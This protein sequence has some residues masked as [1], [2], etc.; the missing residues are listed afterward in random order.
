MQE[1]EQVAIAKGIIQRS[2]A[3]HSP[4]NKIN[5]AKQSKHWLEFGPRHLEQR[6]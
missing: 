6:E 2:K 4:S 5:P 1:F 3:M